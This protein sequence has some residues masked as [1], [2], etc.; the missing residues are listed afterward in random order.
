[1]PEEFVCAGC[2]TRS[3]VAAQFCHVCGLL[4]AP[5]TPVPTARPAGW[6]AQPSAAGAPVVPGYGGS[7]V[8]ATTMS[9]RPIGIAVL[10]VVELVTGLVT[11]FVVYDYGYWANWQF[12]Y[13]DFGRGAVDALMAVGWA[14]VSGAAF[15][16]APRLWSMQ[17]RAWPLAVGLAVGM[18]SLMAAT[19]LIWS[20]SPSD[21]VGA[22]VQ[23]F[24][25]VYLNLSHIRPLF[26]R[27]PLSFM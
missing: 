20:P 25:L 11:L 15:M 1:L 18:I 3:P 13:D 24:V 5:L 8:P 7:A 4:L 22:T 21:F 9:A 19:T 16:V 10:T 6:P 23:L 26:G 2:G 17:A 14:C 27:R 12:S